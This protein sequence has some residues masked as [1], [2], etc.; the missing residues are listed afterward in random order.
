[1]SERQL[2]WLLNLQC[3]GFLKRREYQILVT[4]VETDLQL[5]HNICFLHIFFVLFNYIYENHFVKY[6]VKTKF[7]CCSFF[8]TG[9]LYCVLWLP[10]FR[11]VCRWLIKGYWPC[12]QNLPWKSSKSRDHTKAPPKLFVFK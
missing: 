12:S 1:M 3:K 11:R 4:L 5:R 9:K 2:E 8:N 10:D 7:F 6:T